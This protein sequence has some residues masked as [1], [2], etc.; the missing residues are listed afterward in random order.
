MS[1]SRKVAIFKERSKKR[2]RGISRL[3]HRLIR[4]KEK[5]YTQNV[6]SSSNF[7]DYLYLNRKEIFDSYAYF[8]DDRFDIEHRYSNKEKSEQDNVD[9]INKW[10]RK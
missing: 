6:L 9:H 3:R 7:D 8:D 10:R 1:R 2:Y 4:R 5:L